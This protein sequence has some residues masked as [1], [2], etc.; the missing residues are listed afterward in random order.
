MIAKCFSKWELIIPMSLVNKEHNTHVNSLYSTT[1]RIK[2][3]MSEDGRAH[4]G[5]VNI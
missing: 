4:T 5:P 1:H 2:Y 3:N